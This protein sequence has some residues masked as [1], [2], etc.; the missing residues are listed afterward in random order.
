MEILEKELE[1]YLYDL[2]VGVDDTHPIDV[3]GK[4]YRQVNI[5]GYGKIDLLYV[6]IDPI[7]HVYPSIY[8][9]IVELKRGT[10]DL[11]AIGQICRYK[12]ALDRYIG[13]ITSK[14]HKLRGRIEVRG[15]LVGSKYASGDVCFVGDSVEW[16]SVYNYEVSLS[17][18]ISFCESSGWFNQDENFNSLKS[19]HNEISKEY[20]DTYK[21]L[22]RFHRSHDVE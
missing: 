15:V 5:E 21:E 6:H 19:L 8:I 12:R 10:I 9:D 3:M 11:T 18:G 7:P 13:K 20:I 17:D 2:E 16:L 4:C 1:D 14:Q 22:R